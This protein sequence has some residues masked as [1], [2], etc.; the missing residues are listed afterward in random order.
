MA[1]L[2]TMPQLSSTFWII[3]KAKEVI[4]GQAEAAQENDS[5]MVQQK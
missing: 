3:A 4:M 1:P 2:L 5:T